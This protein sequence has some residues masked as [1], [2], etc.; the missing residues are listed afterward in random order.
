[1]QNPAVEQ[2]V[3][4]GIQL[5]QNEIVETLRNV[6]RIPSVVGSEL[7]AQSFMA[8]RYLSL[9]LSVVT[10][11]ADPAKLTILADYVPSAI[12]YSGRPNIIGIYP[13]KNGGRSLILN[14]HCDVVPPDPLDAWTRDPWGAE[15]DGDKLYGRGAGDM[16]AGLIANFFAL[17]AILDAGITLNGDVML[18]SVIDEEAGGG[19]GTLACLN[20]GFTADAMICTEPHALQISIAHVGVSFFRIRVIGRSSH[21]GQAHLSVNAIEKM[22]PVIQALM[23]FDEERAAAV[24]HPLFERTITRSCHLSIGTMKAGDWPATVAGSAEI[25]GRISFIPGETKAAVQKQLE[26]V[27]RA[28]ADKDP[29]LKDHP[30]VVE[31]VGV[32]T[33]PW[34][35]NPEHP[36]VQTFHSAAQDALAQ[37]VYLEGRKAA[38]DARFGSAFGIATACTGPIAGNVHGADEWVDIPSVIATTQVLARTILRW[39]GCLE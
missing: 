5:M 11:E 30:P 8:D 18:Q 15:I 31:W 17:K 21:V 20:E 4:Q 27:V 35:Q 7:A 10:F 2:Q 33:E 12:P 39:C 29:W 14:G 6:V 13:G 16:K 34:Y 9:P 24:H 23:R 37:P 38:C 26:E 1:M 25:E 28:A 32:Q 22:Y 3:H 19:G 36:F